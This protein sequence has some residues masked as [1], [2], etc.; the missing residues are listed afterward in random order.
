MKNIFR[1]VCRSL[2][3]L[4]SYSYISF[5]HLQV[6]GQNIKNKYKNEIQSI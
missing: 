2:E 5:P 4:S 1:M 3:Y 6:Q